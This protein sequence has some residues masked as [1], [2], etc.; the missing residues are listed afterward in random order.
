[1]ASQWPPRLFRD[2][3]ELLDDKTR[4]MI[5][6]LAE[7]RSLIEQDRG[8]I[9]VLVAERDRLVARIDQLQSILLAAGLPLPPEDLDA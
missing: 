5:E 9:A 4:A 6:G 2:P 7:H 1:M 8:E 3:P